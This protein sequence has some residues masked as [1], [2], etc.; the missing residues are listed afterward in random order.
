MNYGN[1]QVGDS[2][3]AWLA[4]VHIPC[5]P[6]HVSGPFFRPLQQVVKWLR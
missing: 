2:I 1:L 6:T 4:P 3:A 5:I